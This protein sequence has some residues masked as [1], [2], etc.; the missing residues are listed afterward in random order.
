[1]ETLHVAIIPDGNRR[2]GRLNNIVSPK[3]LYDLGMDSLTTISKEAMKLGVTHLSLWGSSYNN[4][5]AR[6]DDLVKALDFVFCKKIANFI[7]QDFIKEYNVKITFIGEW[8][9]ILSKKTILSFEK[10][11]EDTKNNK[12]RFITFFIAYSG[13]RERDYAIKSLIEELNNKELNSSNNKE[14]K[15]N[16][17][18]EKLEDYT[19]LLRKHS[20]TGF[21]PELDFVIRTGAYKDP[22]NSAGFLNLLSDETQFCFPK[23]YWPEYKKETFKKDLTDYLKRERRFGK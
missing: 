12:G 14:I 22:H 8:R 19:A 17:D 16:T 2:W 4:L 10:L 20:W 23:M 9:K 21:L 7:D 5:T 11:M 1:M 15:T 18:F 13:S 3:K 6:T